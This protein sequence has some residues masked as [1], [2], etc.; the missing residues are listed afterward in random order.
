[1]D[2]KKEA[3]MKYL[4][5]AF[6]LITSIACNTA[7]AGGKVFERK[8]HNHWE[9]FI[10]TDTATIARIATDDFQ[11][12]DT[13]ALDF[14]PGNCSPGVLKIISK[15]RNVPDTKDIIA[16][17]SLRVDMNK[18]QDI[19]FNITIE[20][21]FAFVFI[22]VPDKNKILQ[23]M[24]NGNYIRFKIE[25]PNEAPIYQ[26]YSLKGFTAAYKRAKNMCNIINKYNPDEQYFKEDLP[27]DNAPQKIPDAVYF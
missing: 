14:F 9:S 25:I 10:L 7:L 23:E 13:L 1:M 6:L 26:K 8:M 11:Y 24:M 3:G 18:I 16:Y 20:N 15:A 17:G 2:E 22:D 21:N 4:F 19:K 12:G 27:E 5:Y